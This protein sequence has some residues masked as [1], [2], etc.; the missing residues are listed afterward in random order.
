MKKLFVSAVVVS[1][2]KQEK[3]DR[4]IQGLQKLLA[5][6]YEDYEIIVVENVG[7]TGTAPTDWARVVGNTPC[8]RVIRLTRSYK[9]DTAVFAGL[10]AAIGDF[11]C[12][13]DATID[14]IEELPTMIELNQTCDVVQGVSSLKIN[15]GFWGRTGRRLFYW[16]NRRYIDLDIHLDATYF[17]SFNRR[18]INALTGTNRNHRHIRHLIQQVGFSVKLHEYTPTSQPNSQRSLR[19]GI[20]EA[21]EIA[22]S[23]STHPLRFVTWLGVIAGTSNFFYAIYVLLVRIFKRHVAEGWTTTSLQMSV[24]FFLLFGILVILSEYIGRI[25]AES[26]QD[27]RYIVAEELTNTTVIA[28]SG[29]RNITS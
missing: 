20:I 3:L 4:Y 23:Y 22:S 28:N 15:S 29:K 21:V 11:V 27:P 6:T 2:Q 16:Y 25:L 9:H 18:A 19:T 13:L 26:R 10:E 12:V 5:A 17:T 24:M 8:L 14:P 1:Q 7:R